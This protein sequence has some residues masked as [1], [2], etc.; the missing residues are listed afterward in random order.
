MD[1]FYNYVWDCLIKSFEN[2]DALI[3]ATCNFSEKQK[4]KIIRNHFI[5]FDSWKIIYND[6]SD[7]LFKNVILNHNGLQYTIDDISFNPRYGWVAS[8]GGYK[9]YLGKSSIYESVKIDIGHRT[10]FS[11]H[12]TIRGR[13]LLTVGS[14]CSIAFGLYLNIINENH[15]INYSASIDLANESRMVRD[16]FSLN[17]SYVT[18]N[19]INDFIKIGNDVWIGHDVTIFNGI[20]LGHGC[21]IGARS[22][23]TNDCEPFGIYAGIPAKLIRY[24]FPANIIEQLL[25]IEWWGWSEK[26]ILRNKI[27]FDTDLTKFKGEVNN[28]IND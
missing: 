17:L 5:D 15:P 13:G 7:Y 8:G 22:L 19:K 3:E 4:Q 16:G 23:V 20:T 24:R 18:N 1:S 6:R 27:F 26:K 10:Y 11:G 28:I 21:V 25:K 12:S 2:K 9:A 14:Y